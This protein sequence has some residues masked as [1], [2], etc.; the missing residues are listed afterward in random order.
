[1]K[2]QQGNRKTKEYIILRKKRCDIISLARQLSSLQQHAIFDNLDSGPAGFN[3]IQGNRTTK[4][5]IP[6]SR[7]SVNINSDAMF[8]VRG[9]RNE[10]YPRRGFLAW[11]LQKLKYKVGYHP[12]GF[13]KDGYGRA[14][15]AETGSWL[16]LTGKSKE[17]RY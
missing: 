8:V 5:A 12:T 14:G 4:T 10:L 9:F 15:H 13:V 16:V 2:R 17:R 1:M 7:N 3:T 6:R 11:Q